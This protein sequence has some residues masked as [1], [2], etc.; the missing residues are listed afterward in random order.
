MMTTNT[1]VKSRYVEKNDFISINVVSAMMHKV[2]VFKN[3]WKLAI[4]K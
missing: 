4:K 1:L 2:S 3:D